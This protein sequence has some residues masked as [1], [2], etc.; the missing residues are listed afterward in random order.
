MP[1][2]ADRP[3]DVVTSADENRGNALDALHLR[4]DLFG[5]PQERVAGPVV[6]N[7]SCEDGA[8]HRVHVQPPGASQRVRGHMGRLLLVPIVGGSGPILGVAT[9]QSTRVRL[10]QG[11]IRL[12]P[13]RGREARPGLREDSSDPLGDPVDFITTCGCNSTISVILGGCARAYAKA[14][15]DPHDTPQI[16]RRSIPRKP[17]SASASSMSPVIVLPAA[18]Q[19][20]R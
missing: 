14:G 19:G 16:N 10:H 8:N 2:G 1:R 11:L 6:G 15:V 4:Q 17:R 7:Q 12:S 13:G 18:G 3:A 20:R 5:T 9:G